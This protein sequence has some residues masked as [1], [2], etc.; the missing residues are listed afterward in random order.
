MKTKYISLIWAFGDA[1]Y[2]HFAYNA[3]EANW[4]I[5]QGRWVI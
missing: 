5:E 2:I 4:C 1:I 3:N